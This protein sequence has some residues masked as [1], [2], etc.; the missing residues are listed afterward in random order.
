MTGG[1]DDAESMDLDLLGSRTSFFLDSGDVMSPWRMWY[2]KNEMNRMKVFE[3]FSKIVGN[4]LKVC[5][6]ECDLRLLDFLFESLAN[7]TRN[8]IPT[9][10][11][12]PTEVYRWIHF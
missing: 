6:L 11:E 3:F 8:L 12:I 1:G 5:G 10:S 7:E 9:E 2:E 4:Y